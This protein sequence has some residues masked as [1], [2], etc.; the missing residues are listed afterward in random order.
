MPPIPAKALSAGSALAALVLAALALAALAPAVTPGAGMAEAGA[1]PRAGPP[2]AGPVRHVVLIGVPGLRWA[3][4]SAAATPALWRLARQ[5]SVGSLSV[6]GVHTLSC[7]A[8]GWLTLNSGARAAAPRTTAGSC[9]PLPAVTAMPG[10][11][12]FNKPYNETDR[13]GAGFVLLMAAAGGARITVRRGLLAAVSGLAVVAVFA[14]ASYALPGTAHSDL[15]AFTGQV[16]HGGASGTLHRKISSNL[17]SLT[18]SLWIVLIP[19]V[20]A[21]TGVAVFWPARVRARLLVRGYQAI[22]LLRPALA[23]IWLTGVLGWFAEDSG[24]TVPAAG[25]ALVLPLVI[26]I[27]SSLPPSP[28][29]RD[30]AGP[31]GRDDH[32]AAS[33]AA[34]PGYL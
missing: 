1:R 11:V 19:V 22:A 16:L 15:G 7:P 20:L 2:P 9:A 34:G 14:I 10:L 24:V 30:P 33:A 4:V 31:P 21:V 8:D 18:E 25:F 32:R 17:G 26:A 6:T 13:H 23:A 5:G 29:Q 3:G 27:L 28:A 12:S